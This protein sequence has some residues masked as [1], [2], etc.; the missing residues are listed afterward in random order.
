[1]RTDRIIKMATIL[2]LIGVACAA[3]W[4]S[5][6]G[7]IMKDG[8]VNE[9][10]AVS[11]GGHAPVRCGNYFTLYNIVPFSPGREAQAPCVMLVP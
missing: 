3:V 11:T 2:G 5:S 7:I 6:P 9:A 4:A 1:M 10:A 8:G